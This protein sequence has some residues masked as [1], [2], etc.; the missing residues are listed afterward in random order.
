MTVSYARH[1]AADKLLSKIIE[2]GDDFI[3]T[4]IGRYGRPTMVKRDTTIV[5]H[6]LDDKSVLKYLDSCVRQIMSDFSKDIAKEDVDLLNLRD[7]IIAAL[8]QTKY[9][10]TLS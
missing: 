3:E 5:L 6:V 2:L 1:K 9:L 4:Y 10:F 8:N 7:E